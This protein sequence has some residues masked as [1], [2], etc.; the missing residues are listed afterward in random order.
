MISN[1]ELFVPMLYLS[2]LCIIAM[3]FRLFWQMGQLV[4]ADWNESATWNQHVDDALLI[5]NP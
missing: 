3:S 4:R 2:Y 5:A 1:L